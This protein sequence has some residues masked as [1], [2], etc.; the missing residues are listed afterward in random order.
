MVLTVTPTEARAVSL[1]EATTA[2]LG[3]SPFTSRGM[4]FKFCAIET[5]RGE[6]GALAALWHVAGERELSPLAATEQLAAA[7]EA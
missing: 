5:L 4:L 3:R 1:C 2:A 6:S 7:G